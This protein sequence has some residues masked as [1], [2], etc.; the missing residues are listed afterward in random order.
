MEQLIVLPVPS[1]K[2]TN[3]GD[4]FHIQ[5]NFAQPHEVQIDPNIFTTVLI[6]EIH[7]FLMQ[8]SQTLS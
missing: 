3:M 7:S 2:F 1:L 4:K 6:S 8:D 5:P